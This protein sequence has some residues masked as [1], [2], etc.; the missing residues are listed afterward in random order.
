MCKT[1]SQEVLKFKYN[2]DVGQVSL[3]S[4]M[5]VMIWTISCSW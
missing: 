4:F 2:L 3:A 1:T 5:C